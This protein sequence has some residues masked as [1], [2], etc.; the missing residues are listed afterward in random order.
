MKYIAKISANGTTYDKIS[1]SLAA[2]MSIQGSWDGTEEG[3][4]GKFGIF[5]ISKEVYRQKNPA[6]ATRHTDRELIELAKKVVADK[7]EKQPKQKRKAKEIR[8]ANQ[9]HKAG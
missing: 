6:K 1:D 8:A 9:K 4:L 3:A 2:S 7:K 5:Y